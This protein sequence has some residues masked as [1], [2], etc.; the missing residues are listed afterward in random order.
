M[1]KLLNTMEEYAEDKLSVVY[2]EDRNMTEYGKI[3]VKNVSKDE[4][5]NDYKVT[6]E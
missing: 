5:K 6:I 2:I 1:E 4:W 3:T